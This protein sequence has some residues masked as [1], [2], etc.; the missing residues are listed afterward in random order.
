MCHLGKPPNLSRL[1]FPP[2]FQN[3]LRPFLRPSSSPPLAASSLTKLGFHPSSFK[4]P[5]PKTWDASHA[6]SF[7]ALRRAVRHSTSPCL[8]VLRPPHP[9]LSLVR[10]QLHRRAANMAITIDELDNLVRSF[11]E[12][13]G[14]QVCLDFASL[15]CLPAC[16]VRDEG[17]FVTD[18]W[19]LW[20]R[21]AKSR[22]SFSE[23]GKQAIQRHNMAGALSNGSHLVQRR[24]RFLA[25]GR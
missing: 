12:G 3:N 7:R 8:K 17:N 21:L 25:H 9:A 4:Q 24:P 19:C 20:L 16:A 14:E 6:L 2:F 13:R 11:Y 23:P 5:R 15:D 1:S 22:P 18:C 10:R